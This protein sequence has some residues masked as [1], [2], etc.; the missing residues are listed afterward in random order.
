MKYVLALCL[1]TSTQFLMGCSKTV[2]T[3]EC[4]WSKQ[5]EF[6]P[7]T[8]QWLGGLDWPP[9]AYGDFNKVSD[10]NVLHKKYC[11]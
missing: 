5:I 2:Q 3:T 1:L 7:N 10:H 11:K 4:S 9:T 8:K 6:H